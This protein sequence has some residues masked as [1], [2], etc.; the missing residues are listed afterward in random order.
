M[1]QKSTV[2]LLVFQ[3]DI[4]IE[5]EKGWKTEDVFVPPGF[6]VA[7]EMTAEEE[8]PE[9][10]AGE[11][12]YS[13]PLGLGGVLMNACVGTNYQP[14]DP[15]Y[16]AYWAETICAVSKIVLFSVSQFIM[17]SYLNRKIE[18]VMLSNCIL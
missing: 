11:Q 6:H 17:F 12:P 4:D 5:P 1:L 13:Y 8:K 14:G 3:L 16:D 2:F 10:E 9:G 15:C 7:A 18:R